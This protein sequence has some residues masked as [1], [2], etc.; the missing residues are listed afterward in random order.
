MPF[1]GAHHF[2]KNAPIPEENDIQTWSVCGFLSYLGWLLRKPEFWNQCTH[3]HISG[4]TPYVCT[5]RSCL[6]M[7]ICCFRLG[8]SICGQAQNINL[9]SRQDRILDMCITRRRRDDVSWR[10][11][12]GRTAWLA[13]CDVRICGAK[14]INECWTQLTAGEYETKKHVLEILHKPGI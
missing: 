3:F 6:E 4:C 12:M 7:S 8:M 14:C 10:W 13:L 11:R 9:C 1:F 2:H 5:C